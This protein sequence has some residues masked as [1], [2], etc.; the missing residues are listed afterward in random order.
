MINDGIFSLAEIFS[1]PWTFNFRP[2]HYFF[3][4]AHKRRKGG[5]FIFI[6]KRIRAISIFPSLFSRI[7]PF[8]LSP[9]MRR[10][11]FI[12]SGLCMETREGKKKNN[13]KS[14]FCVSMKCNLQLCHFS[15]PPLFCQEKNLNSLTDVCLVCKN[16]PLCVCPT[17]P[18]LK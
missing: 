12:N 13:T 1:F 9:I 11:I 17:S 8:F 6:E 18:V 4:F 2:L 14:P 10:T 5:T 15:P 16:V 7:S 3:I